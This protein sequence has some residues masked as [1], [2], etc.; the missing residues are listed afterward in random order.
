[1]KFRKLALASAAM[2][3]M[4]VNGLAT[5]GVTGLPGEGLL[6]PLVLGTDGDVDADSIAT[7]VTLSVPGTIGQDTM[8]NFFTAPHST[9]P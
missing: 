4:G 9:A 1:M 3:A 2:A 5:A 7:Y 6:V 8:I